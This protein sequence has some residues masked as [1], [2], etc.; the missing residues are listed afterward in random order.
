MLVCGVSAA[1]AATISISDSAMS[2]T[3]WSEGYVTDGGAGE[4]TTQQP[5]GGANDNGAYR[6]TLLS[7]PGGYIF[8]NVYHISNA[9]TYNP[10]TFGDILTLDFAIDYKTDGNTVGQ[11]F[12]VAQGANVWFGGYT[13]IATGGSWSG[14]TSIA[15]VAADFQG[16]FGA[17]LPDFSANGAPITFGYNTANSSTVGGYTTLSGYDNFSVTITHDSSTALVPEPSVLA[18]LALGLFGHARRR[19]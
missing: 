11:G 1:S 19:R 3:N 9:F 17:T 16:F 8:I 2:S 4:A 5:A 14:R 6:E 7:V 10:A 18:L 12:V 15:M 13:G